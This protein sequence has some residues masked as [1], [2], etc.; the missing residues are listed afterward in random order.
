ML[1]GMPLLVVKELAGHKDIK[2]T[3]RYYA[4]VTHKDLREWVNKIADVG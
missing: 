3:M 4:E 2:T 1:Q